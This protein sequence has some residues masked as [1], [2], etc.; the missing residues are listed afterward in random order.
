MLKRLAVVARGRKDPAQSDMRGGKLGI[1]LQQAREDFPGGFHVILL[2]S[3]E[4]GLYVFADTRLQTRA[5]M[6]RR[7]SHVG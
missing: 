4:A 1:F 6:S 2:Q 3:S 7:E 5:V